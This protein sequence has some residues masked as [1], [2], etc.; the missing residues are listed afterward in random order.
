MGGVFSLTE[1]AAKK[2]R[3]EDDAI[4]AGIAGC[5]AGLVASVKSAFW[6]KGM[7]FSTCARLTN[8]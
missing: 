7:L 8:G 5:A 6:E 3:G 4:N 1:C 2:I